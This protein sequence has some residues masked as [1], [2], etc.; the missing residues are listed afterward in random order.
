M[1]KAGL[2]TVAAGHNLR[3]TLKVERYALGWH[4]DL[5]RMQALPHTPSTAGQVEPLARRL[6]QGAALSSLEPAPHNARDY[7]QV[8]SNW[9][10]SAHIQRDRLA[11]THSQAEHWA[12]SLQWETL[13]QVERVVLERPS[14]RVGWHW[15]SLPSTKPV[16]A[17]LFA[18]RSMF[19]Y[20]FRTPQILPRSEND[21]ILST[22]IPW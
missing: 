21:P 5:I 18:S 8:D 11:A 19:D 9:P 3:T 10:E 12:T 14:S 4:R 15:V 22:P 17:P 7:P 6:P 20:R 16:P 13:V 1:P 2:D